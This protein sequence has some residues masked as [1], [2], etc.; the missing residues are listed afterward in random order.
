MFVIIYIAR[1]LTSEVAPRFILTVE[2]EPVDEKDW[3]RWYREEHLNML[4]TLPGYRRSQ[5][6]KIGNPVPVLTRGEPTKFF[7]IHELDHF[8]GM[9][10]PEAH[11]T[12]NT[13]WT[14]KHVAE[15]KVMIV[16]GFEKVQAEGY[17]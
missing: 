13:E 8:D 14:K 9:S 17:E 3:D 10:G 15:A 7:A 16:R 11:A 6:Y 5:R 1:M 4:N 12:N 2:M